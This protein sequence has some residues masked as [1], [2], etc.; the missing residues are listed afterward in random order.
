MSDQQA[1]RR[2][3]A[4]DA[5]RSG[6]S[7][8]QAPGCYGL[9]Q[10]G[11]E[12]QEALDGLSNRL[13]QEVKEHGPLVVS[14]VVAPRV[15]VQVPLQ[16]LGR[17]RVVDAANPVLHQGEEALDGLSVN[18]P[19]H[20]DPLLVVDAFVGVLPLDPA[21]ALPLVRVDDGGGQNVVTDA[22][23]EREA[24]TSFS[25]NICPYAPSALDD[26]KD[27]CSRLRIWTEFDSGEGGNAAVSVSH[28]TTDPG[29]VGF[30]FPGQ[31]RSLVGHDLVANLVEHSPSGLVRHAKLALQLL[32]RDSASSARH[33][34]H[35]VEPQMQRRG[36]LV[37]DRPRCRV[38]V[39]A[40]G[41]AC[42]RLTPLRRLVALERPFLVAL[43]TMRVLSVRR[44]PGAPK[45]LQTGGI[46]RVFA[47]ELHEGVGRLR[48]RCADR[49]KAVNRGHL[50]L[51][52]GKNASAAATAGAFAF[53][54]DLQVILGLASD[55]AAA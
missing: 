4:E 45:P 41:L 3:E 9:L 47:H 6:N 22:R 11:H 18:V 2:A 7:G 16:P 46:V 54:R 51:L 10:E 31:S 43:R 30:N 15:L 26:P 24:V 13:V 14:A 25:E 19:A 33:D 35:G 20:V 40:A 37:K 42:P 55:G 23:V 17:D 38:N 8:A 12:A 32:G 44:E 52:V 39:V 49:V 28:P 36:R 34:V 27:H 48:G 50:A 21:I 1:T 5:Q 53:S 29:F